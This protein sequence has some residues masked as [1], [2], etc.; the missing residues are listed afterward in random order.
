MDP[1][2]AFWDTS[3]YPGGRKM[4]WIYWDQPVEAVEKGPYMLTCLTKLFDTPLQ[5]LLPISGPSMLCGC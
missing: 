5:I 2:E 3:I 1:A 4:F